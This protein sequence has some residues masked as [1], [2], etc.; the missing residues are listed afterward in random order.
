MP[1]TRARLF[2]D[3]VD[4]GSF[5]MDLRVERVCRR[6]GWAFERIPFEVRPPP[7]APVD[8]DEPA[9][10]AYWRVTADELTAEGCRIVAPPRVPW[11]RKAHELGFHARECAVFEEVH[12][13]LF[14]AFHTAGQD[15]GR[16][17]VLLGVAA[18]V[19]QEATGTR[20]VLGVDR[21]AQAV[22]EA[23]ERA[24]GEGVRGVPTLQGGRELLEGVRN[25]E[26][27]RAFLDVER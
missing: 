3:Y 23:R 7:E 10:R 25:D 13:A 12:R 8:P 17:D 21:H 19:G 20:A 4:P 24:V 27:I 11:T 16:V 2:Y 6:L 5:L 9:W 18:A 15:I 26:E 14:E 1:D 22:T